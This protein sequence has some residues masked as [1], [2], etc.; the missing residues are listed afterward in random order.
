MARIEI[1]AHCPLIGHAMIGWA[2]N[3]IVSLAS[4][5]FGKCLL[6]WDTRM[7]III[8][9]FS[10]A[11]VSRMSLI[12]FICV[13]PRKF[14]LI[15]NWPCCKKWNFLSIILLNLKFKEDQREKPFANPKLK[16]DWGEDVFNDSTIN[17]AHQSMYNF[18]HFATQC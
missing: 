8:E 16:I 11:D 13:K 9:C 15:F 12:K 17:K 5:W 2:R 18:R 10:N 14:T 4:F 3:M 1:R 7:Y 6:F